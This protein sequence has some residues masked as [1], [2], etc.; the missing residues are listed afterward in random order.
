LPESNT[1]FYRFKSIDSCGYVDTISNIG[2]NILLRAKANGNLTNTLLWNGYEQFGGIVGR[3]EVYRMI[4]NNGSWVLVTDQLGANDTSF[5]DDIRPFGAST[6]HFCYFVKAVEADN[7][8]NFVDEYGQ[9]FNCSS[10]QVC[11]TQNARVFVPTAFNPNSDVEENRVWKPTNVFARTNSYELSVYNR[12][13]DKVFYTT[14]LNEAWDGTFQNEPQPM[15]VYTFLLK[16]RSLE[17]VPIEERGSFTI[18]R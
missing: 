12:W 11:V 5:I 3:Y 13:G 18:I 2:R 8:V 10:N 4:D 16:Y 17:G 14:D 15:G 6:G 7:P 9:A 1:Y